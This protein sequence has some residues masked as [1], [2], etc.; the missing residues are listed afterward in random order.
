M[1]RWYLLY[2]KRGEMTRAIAHLERQGVNCFVPKMK[3]EKI[4][5]GKKSSIEEPMFPN[6]LFIHFDYEQGPSFTTVRS[7][8]GVSNFIAFGPNPKEIAW[9]IIDDLRLLENEQQQHTEVRLPQPGDK[10]LLKSGQFAGLEA[11]YHQADGEK[12]S[13]LMLELI[14]KPVK[15]SV[16][17]S[18]IEM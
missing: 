2:C 18:D 3:V 11:I 9:E 6:Y 17:N 12:R 8:R 7:T 13:I 5:R 14:S 16:D 10:V 15:M 1:K 4:V